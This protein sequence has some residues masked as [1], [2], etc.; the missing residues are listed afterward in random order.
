MM[1]L[2]TIVELNKRAARKSRE[3]GILPVAISAQVLRSCTFLPELRQ[4]GV[5][6]PFIGDRRPKGFKALGE[7]L[8]VD[9]SG[10]GQ[11][12][13]R[14][15]TFKETL[16]EMLNLTLEHGTLAWATIEHG[17]FQAYL[18]PFKIRG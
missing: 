1:S 15:L 2:E 8:F 13:E 9:T 11:E 14:A 3:L 6:I 18:Q 4:K 12:G 16:G 5:N 10:W 17:Q 7:P